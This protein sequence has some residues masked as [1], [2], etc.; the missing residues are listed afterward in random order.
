LSSLLFVNITTVG[1][2]AA[3]PTF[4]PIANLQYVHAFVA[5][6]T[7]ITVPVPEGNIVEAPAY[8]QYLL[9]VIDATNRRSAGSVETNYKDDPLA[10]DI[11]IPVQNVWDATARLFNCKAAGYYKAGAVDPATGLGSVSCESC[12]IGHY[13]P[14]ESNDKS[15]CTYGALAC[16]DTNYATNAVL[17]DAANGK[18]NKVL[19]LDEVNDLIPPTQIAQWRRISCCGSHSGTSMTWGTVNLPE[20]GCAIGT[21]GPGTYLFTE[22]Y[23]DAGPYCSGV[24]DS[25]G[26]VIGCTSANIAVFDH[27]VGYKSMHGEGVYHNFVDTNNETFTSWTLHFP[28]VAAGMIDNTNQVNISGLADVPIWNLCVYELM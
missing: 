28:S 2:A 22:R 18:T 15:V 10:T 9:A 16:K 6:A 11:A 25:T 23:G 19:T 20:N 24:T 14:V 13:C 4:G 5:R 7:G 3:E 8:V 26:T 1:A 12:T 21:I 17:P 27:K